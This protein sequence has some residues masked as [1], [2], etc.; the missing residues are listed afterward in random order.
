MRYG[1][2][3][4]LMFWFWLSFSLRQVLWTE[5]GGYGLYKYSCPPS[6]QNAR[7]SMYSYLI[8]GQ[9]FFFFF[10][11]PSL[12]WTLVS[13][14][15]IRVQFLLPLSLKIVSVLEGKRGGV[16]VEFMQGL[17][18]PSS[19]QHSRRGGSLLAFSP[20]PLRTPMGFQQENPE[21]RCELFYACSHEGF[22]LSC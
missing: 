9:T 20:S 11:F 21:R 19:T 3:H 8:Q 17:L 5:V 10:F 2:G 22:T 1:G 6:R 4:S 15:A 18:F 12:S 7:L 16:W 13:T 14:S